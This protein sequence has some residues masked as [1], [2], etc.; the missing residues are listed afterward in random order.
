MEQTRGL[1]LANRLISFC[2]KPHF[3]KESLKFVSKSKAV[4]TGNPVRRSL[5]TPNPTKPSWI[6]KILIDQYSI[7]Q[8]FSGFRDHQLNNR[9]SARNAYQTVGGDPPVRCPSTQRNYKGAAFRSPDAVQKSQ[10]RYN[11]REWVADQELAWIYQQT[12][13][14]ISRSGANTVEELSRFA[15]PPFWSHCRLHTN[16]NNSK[17]RSDETN[18]WSGDYWPKSLN[19]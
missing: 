4:V 17:R 9:A 6:T 7:S 5:F 2:K 3:H 15:I 16:K 19:P 12:Q 18:W 14:V 10:D 8:G 13:I 1:G 11:V